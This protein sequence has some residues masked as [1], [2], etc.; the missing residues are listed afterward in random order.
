MTSEDRDATEVTNTT[1]TTSGTHAADAVKPDATPIGDPRDKL[2]MSTMWGSSPR[3]RRHVDFYATDRFGTLVDLRTLMRLAQDK[4]GVVLLGSV[5]R[6]HRYRDLV[7]AF[8]LKVTRAPRNRPRVLITDA[9]WQQESKALARLTGLPARWFALPTKL[10]VR[11]I[12]G[13][14]VRYGVLSTREK[15]TFSTVWGVAPDRV[16]FTPFPATVDAQTP[17]S[18]GDYLFAGGN[19]LRDY[20]LVAQALPGTGARCRVASVW[21][22]PEPVEGLETGPVEHEDFVRLLAGCRAAIVPLEQE[23]RSA[24]QQSYLNAMALGKPVIVTEA[25]GVRDY[26]EDGVT[27]VVVPPDPDA[28]RAAIIDVMDPAK[29]PVYEEMGRRAQEWVRE[30]AT[31]DAYKDRVLLDAIGVPRDA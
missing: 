1:N 19:S 24:G 17:T 13:A 28:L 16:V 20:D 25:P 26:V 15:E 3:W 30:N 4:A 10:V 22:P 5:T 9:T 21:Q 8:L 11:L 31:Q 2:V 14:H 23:V 29:A 18:V 27:G 7:F 6:R 12:D